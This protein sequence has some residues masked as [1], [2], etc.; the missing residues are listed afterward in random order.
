M[1]KKERAKAQSAN[2]GHNERQQH[3]T[4]LATRLDQLF[5]QA[6]KLPETDSSKKSMLVRVDDL[7]NR[8]EFWQNYL[9]SIQEE[10]KTWDKEVH[11]IDMQLSGL[12]EALVAKSE[13]DQPSD[14]SLPTSWRD[15][16][17]EVTYLT[18]DERQIRFSKQQIKLGKKFDKRG[19]HLKVIEVGDVAPDGRPGIV[20]SEMKGFDKKTKVKGK[21]GDYR[22]QARYEQDVLYFPGLR[23]FH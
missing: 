3:I 7:S 16:E 14:P 12:E 10:L 23:T 11:Q 5:K 18:Q 21:G 17:P 2:K 20:P 6:N 9:K 22:F 15:I 8:V 13:A 19:K 4:E 1:V